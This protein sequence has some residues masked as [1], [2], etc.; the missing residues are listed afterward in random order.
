[1]KDY[2]NFYWNITIKQNETKQAHSHREQLGGCQRLWVGV[3]GVAKWVKGSKG[4]NFQ[5]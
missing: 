5:L 1:M 2:L 3:K 4:T